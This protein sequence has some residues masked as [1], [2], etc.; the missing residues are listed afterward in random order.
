MDGTT[1]KVT[2]NLSRSFRV[3]VTPIKRDAVTLENS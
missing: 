2:Q 3:A 1:V